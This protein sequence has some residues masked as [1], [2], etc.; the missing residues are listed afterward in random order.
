MANSGPILIIEDDVDDKAMFQEILVELNIKNQLVW[1]QQCDEAFH[2]LK[3]TTVQPFIIFS[4]INLPIQ[5][6]IEFKR[7]IDSD[8]DLRRKSIPFVFLFHCHQPC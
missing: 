8:K 3:S 4:D 2:Y 1:F 7:Q 6:G 5:S